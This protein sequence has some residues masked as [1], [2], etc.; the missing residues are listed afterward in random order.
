MDQTEVDQWISIL[1]ID[2]LHIYFVYVC[3]KVP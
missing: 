2:F 1:N 3:G